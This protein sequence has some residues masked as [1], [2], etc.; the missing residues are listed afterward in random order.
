MRDATVAA[1]SLLERAGIG[2]GE[3]ARTIVG[4]SGCRLGHLRALGVVIRGDVAYRS[5]QFKALAPTR[6]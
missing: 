5:P 3:A 1:S 6:R 2:I 4:Q